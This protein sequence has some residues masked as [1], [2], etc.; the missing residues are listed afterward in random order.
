MAEI[1]TKKEIIEYLE[2][3]LATINWDEEATLYGFV[4]YLKNN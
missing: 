1:L 2:R 3:Y 4:E